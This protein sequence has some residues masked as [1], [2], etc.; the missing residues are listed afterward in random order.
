MPQ[1]DRLAV[2]ERAAHLRAVG[3]AALARHLGAERGALRRVLVERGGV[4]HTE[5]FTPV[6]IAAGRPGDVI[7]ARV[8]GH[9]GRA[10][11]AVAT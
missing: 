3:G 4:G 2:K 11:L 7:A 1:V 9:T 8:T 6:E 5:H 10:L